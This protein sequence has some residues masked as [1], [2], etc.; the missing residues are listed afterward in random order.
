MPNPRGTWNVAEAIAA[1]WVSAGLDAAFRTAWGALH[2]TAEFLT[3]N[4]TEAR[5]AKDPPGHP[6]P[7]CI[8]ELGT[9][10]P[11]GNSSG[12][13]QSGAEQIANGDAEGPLHTLIQ[14][15]DVPVQFTVYGTTKSQVRQFTKLVAAVF[16]RA[17]FSLTDDEHIETFRDPDF[18]TRHDDKTWS[19]TLQY[20]IRIDAKYAA[21]LS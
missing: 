18:S 2:Q 5:P 4:D 19:H 17:L 9:P 15:Q 14:T 7:Y 1:K 21:A 10:V 12:R 3:L 8:W 13:A 11:L 20:R 6:R 16:D